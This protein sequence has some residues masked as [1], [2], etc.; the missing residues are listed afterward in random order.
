MLTLHPSSFLTHCGVLPPPRGLV[1]KPLQARG[2]ARSMGVSALDTRP[3]FSTTLDN[4]VSRSRPPLSPFALADGQSV[5]LARGPAGLGRSTPLGERGQ[6]SAFS[7]PARPAV[8]QVESPRHRVGHP[9]AS[10]RSAALQPGRT[11]ARFL[12]NLAMV[13]VPATVP[14]QGLRPG[15]RMANEETRFSIDAVHARALP[16]VSTPRTTVGRARGDARGVPA[17][18]R[19]SV[20][21]LAEP[22]YCIA[23]PTRIET[24]E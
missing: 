11:F 14:V 21:A 4:A 20:F 12:H 3:P 19:G 17:S 23:V 5:L 1:H 13:R 10:A 9:P 6:T 16:P 18:L 22:A 8:A 7:R 24:S 15:T 2:T